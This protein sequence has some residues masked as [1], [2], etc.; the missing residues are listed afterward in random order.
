MFRGLVTATLCLRHRTIWSFVFYVIKWQ[1]RQDIKVLLLKAEA[2]LSVLGI[3]YSI[4]HLIRVWSSFPFLSLLCSIRYE[5]N[6]QWKKCNQFL[7]IWGGWS[8][9]GFFTLCIIFTETSEDFFPMKGFSLPKTMRSIYSIKEALHLS[10][11][12]VSQ[13]GG[14]KYSLYLKQLLSAISKATD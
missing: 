5:K 8:S 13:G 1:A 4:K 14:R 2:I 3:R 6:V 7:G 9:G 11:M 12:C 10:S